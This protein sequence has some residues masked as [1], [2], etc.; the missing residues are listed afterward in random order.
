MKLLSDAQDVFTRNVNPALGDVPAYV[1]GPTAA[2]IAADIGIPPAHLVKL[3]SNEAPL[4]PSPA[5]RE[6]LRDIAAGDELHRYPSPDMSDLREAIAASVD[7]DPDQVML[8][9]GSSETWPVIVR[10]FSQVGDGVLALEPSL[11]S[12]Q[13]IAV[14]QER[15][16]QVVRLDPPFEVEVGTVLAGVT[17]RTRVVFISTPNNTTS[18]A[19][20]LDSLREIAAGA[21][22]AVLVVDE[23]YI[24]A[25]PDYKRRTAVQL[26]GEVPNLIVTRTFSKMYGLAGLRVGYAAGPPEAIATLRKARSLWA[27]SLPAKV[28]AM[29]AIGDEE[30]LT[31]N[32]QTT[33]AGRSQLLAG[34]SAWPEVDIA[35]EPEGGFILFRVEGQTGEEVASSLLQDG[36]MVRADLAEGFVRVSVGTQ[37]QNAR[38]LATLGRIISGRQA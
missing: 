23:H 33:A 29:A 19:L 28:A 15:T 22:D 21:S 37:G 4:G 14:V 5:V 32:I 2:A 1:P 16:P 10:A 6:A 25:V 26:L 11:R 18:L 31:L 8:S 3:S 24:E 38:F 7:L 12:Y 17:D 35:G 27:V 34:L 36:I 13:Q 9:D 20:S 30:H